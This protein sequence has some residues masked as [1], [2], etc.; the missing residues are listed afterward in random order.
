MKLVL[1][2]MLIC[3]LVQ[4]K[5]FTQITTKSVPVIIMEED[6]DLIDDASE[7]L[8]HM[9][10]KPFEYQIFPTEVDSKLQVVLPTT[11]IFTL[12]LVDE[13]GNVLFSHYQIFGENQV[14]LGHL[15]AA[16][17]FVEL[18]CPKGKVVQEITKT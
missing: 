8:S 1:S 5:G 15:K 16:K 2:L 11:E 4:V 9:M 14:N 7:D 6:T 3:L 18:S 17:Y 12:R 13:N 10:V